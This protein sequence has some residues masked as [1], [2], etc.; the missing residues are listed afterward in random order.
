M[1]WPAVLHKTGDLFASGRRPRPRCPGCCAPWRP[2]PPGRSWSPPGR[3]PVRWLPRP[4]TGRR[5]RP[6]PAAEANWSAPSLRLTMMRF[7]GLVMLKVI[8][9]AK[10]TPSAM[11]NTETHAHHP[12]WCS[13]AISEA[14]T[15]YVEGFLIVLA[16]KARPP[17]AM[18]AGRLGRSL[19]G[20]RLPLALG[21]ACLYRG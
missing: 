16:P 10:S 19:D 21:L 7:M 18:A 15:G 13:G 8:S 14:S 3:P 2:V 4:K 20:Q 11:P 12:T 17:G 9:T 5:P 1:D 6:G